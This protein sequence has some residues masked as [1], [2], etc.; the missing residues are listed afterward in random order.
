MRTL[1]TFA[2]TADSWHSGEFA[3]DGST[4]DPARPCPPIAPPDQ[5]STAPPH[6]IRSMWPYLALML[7]CAGIFPALER[8]L[9]WRLFNWLPPIV[10]TYLC[11]TALAAAGLWRVE[12]EIAVAQ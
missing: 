7:L 10:W 9:R 8:R 2:Y 4:R 6:M 12:G 1:G 5:R 11:V 3:R